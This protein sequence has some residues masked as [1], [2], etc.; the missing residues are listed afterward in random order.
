MKYTH[1][2]NSFS[3]LFSVSAYTVYDIQ[4]DKISQHNA[5]PAQSQVITDPDTWISMRLIQ[6]VW[7]M[8][9]KK[10]AGITYS[11][12]QIEKMHHLPNAGHTEKH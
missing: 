11:R 10:R 7:T 9:K 1:P 8:L 3:L 2:Q 6:P 12:N 4:M 5:R